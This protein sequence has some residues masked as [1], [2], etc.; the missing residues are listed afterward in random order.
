[1]R[2]TYYEE[3]PTHGIISTSVLYG[4]PSAIADK[5][6][7]LKQRFANNEIKCPVCKMPLKLLKKVK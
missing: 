4:N 2:E 5:M 6:K 1:M 7:S 3:C